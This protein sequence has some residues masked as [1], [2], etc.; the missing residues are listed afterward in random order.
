MKTQISKW[1]NSLA[2]RIPKAFI[3]QLDLVEGEDVFLSL[4]EDS[5]ILRPKKYELKNLVDQVSQ[6]NIHSETDWGGTLGQEIW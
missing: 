1:G 5:L 4:K 6:S 3:L 2:F